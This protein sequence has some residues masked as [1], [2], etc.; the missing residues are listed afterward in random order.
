MKVMRRSEKEEKDLPSC[1]L[2]AFFNDKSCMLSLVPQG[3][4]ERA[5]TDFFSSSSQDG[6]SLCV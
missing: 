5:Q 1:Y 3:N 6:S 2:P 4:G